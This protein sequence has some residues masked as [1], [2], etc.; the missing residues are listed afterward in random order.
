MNKYLNKRNFEKALK[1]KGYSK[2]GIAFRIGVTA[3][4]ISKWLNDDNPQVISDSHLKALSIVLEVSDKFLI[5]ENE[6][7]T[8]GDAINNLFPYFRVVETKEEIYLMKFPSA[9]PILAIDRDWWESNYLIKAER[10]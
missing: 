7:L 10:M 8:N 3:P 4:T 1:N 6:I 9:Y 2:S 5:G